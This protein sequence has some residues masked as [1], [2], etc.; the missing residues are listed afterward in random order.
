MGGVGKALGWASVWEQRRVRSRWSRN[1]R[2]GEDL[3]EPE[4]GEP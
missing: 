2:H 3:G 1:D 4:Q